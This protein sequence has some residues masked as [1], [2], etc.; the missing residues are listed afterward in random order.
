MAG[1][2]PTKYKKE[3]VE[4]ARKL[5]KLGATTQELADFFNVSGFTIDQWAIVHEEFSRAIKVG[6]SPADDR[7]EQSLYHRAMGY[8][9]PETIVKV[10]SGELVK[11]EVMKH[12][13]PDPMALNFWLRN[14]RPKDWRASPVDNNEGKK[15]ESITITRLTK[16][17]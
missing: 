1:G 11:V 12:Y 3:Y 6:K 15:S 2:R 14:R 9:H 16:D 17:G 8:S 7:V 4:Q 10:V 5:C 13:P